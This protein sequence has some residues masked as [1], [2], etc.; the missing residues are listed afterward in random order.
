MKLSKLY[1]NQPELF[2]P[3]N[4]MT[5]LNVVMAEIRLPENKNKDTHNL[6]KTTLSLLLDFCL[7]AQ[8]DNELFLFKHQEL[9]KD[10]IFFLEIELFDGSFVTVQRSVKEAS[11]ISF[12]KHSARH[13]DFSLLSIEQWDHINVPFERARE[14]LDGLLDLH[15]L[16]PWT[17]R[18]SLGY[19]LRLQN[20]YDDIF[21]LS[22]FLG[23]HAAW[24]PYL[25]HILGFN[26]DIIKRHYEK[27]EAFK[28]KEKQANI[29]NKELGGSVE[30][31]SRI[32]GILHL[33]KIDADKK[34]SFLNDFDFRTEDENTTKLLVD[35]LD[36]RIATLNT[37]RYSLNQNKKKIEASLAE[38]QILFDPEHAQKLFK[39]AG[40][41]FQGQIKKDFEQLIAFNKA[42]TEERRTYLLEELD[43][44]NNALKD[45]NIELNELGKQRSNAL[46]FL[47]S[48]DIFDK[49]KQV[50]D[51]LV[52]LK[53]DIASLERQRDSLHRLQELRSEIRALN[54]EK[55]HLQSQIEEDVERQNSDSNS[56]FSSIREYFS[57][58]VEQV[59]DRKALLTVSP[60]Q[61]GHLE[62]KAEILDDSGNS[63]SADK[64]RTY[65]K[66][67]CIAFDLAILK[68]NLDKKFP[69]FVYHDGIFESLDNRKK[70]NLLAVIRQYTNFG[71]QHIITL[72]DSEIPAPNGINSLIF[73]KEEIILLLHDEN[74]Q[75]KLFK[76]S[77]WIN[78]R[79]L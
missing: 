33:K 59:I 65:R 44:I 10:F 48:T 68:A 51:E 31:I 60:N 70:E 39:E 1:S 18:Q 38:E 19:L 40:I 56:L 13:Q 41:L 71:L 26:A 23:K 50:T 3:V 45:I 63:T 2:E 74:D 42:I 4:F 22:K 14:L 6:G 16:K 52:I 58:I 9:F 72:I 36:E 12:K 66:L 35:T 43:E 53:S 69:H 64:G 7:L 34:Q 29:I 54:E 27:E 49:Y 24:K 47:S 15:V 61:Q 73:N 30:D 55:S 20:D 28:E 62:F 76:M 21:K 67:L 32:E 77:E 79:K 57:E 8:R 25:A 46:S 17:F 5:G 78:T 11:K 75:G 37:Q